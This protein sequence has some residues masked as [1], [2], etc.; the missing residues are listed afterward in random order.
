MEPA[1]VPAIEIRAMG[2]DDV[3][4]VA[5]I[6]LLAQPHPW[7]R[8]V[9]LEELTRAWAAVDVLRERR[10]GPIDA[11]LNYWIV[12]DEVHVLN[13]AT[14]PDRRRRGFAA[15]LL[16][17]VEAVARERG[18]R[19]ITLEVRRRN[20]AAMRLYRAHRY[21]PVGMRPRYYDNG[22]DAIVMLRELDQAD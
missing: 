3:D 13:V 15:R 7:G 11:F 17:H 22:E 1:D 6:E 16:D 8:E 20:R 14:R 12:G 19:A 4:E 10:G 21:R 9:F 5:A 18:C 2:R